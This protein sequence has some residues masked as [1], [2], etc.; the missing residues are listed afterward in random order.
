ML[1]QRPF[2]QQIRLYIA[3]LLVFGVLFAQWVG[4]TH[5]VEHPIL[6]KADVVLSFLNGDVKGTPDKSV[7][8]SCDAFDAAALGVALP[9]VFSVV[10]MLTY[11]QIKAPRTTDSSW[12]AEF[13]R[14]FL[15]RAPPS[16]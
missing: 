6:W 13:F 10:A 7:L 16:G 14:H 12:N 2:Q 1:Y 3:V 11:A 5:R 4:L 15:S 8:H 9:G